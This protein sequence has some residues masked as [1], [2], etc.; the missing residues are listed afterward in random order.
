MKTTRFVILVFLLLAVAGQA[1]AQTT[2][3]RLIGSVVDAGN[4]VLAGVTV[5][6]ASPALI[7]GAQTK[8]TDG[9]GE[10]TFLSIAPGVY[11]LRAELPGFIPQER[12]KVKVPLGGAAAVFIAMPGSA[13]TGEIEVTDLTP[14][15][16]PT[17]VNTG[18]VF[19]QGYMQ[20]S[21]I[22]SGN[23]S[24]T[25]VVNQTA[26]V[27]GGGSWG[28]VAQPRVFG[29]TIGENAYFI[30]GMDSTNPTMATATAVLNF[31]AIDEIQLQTGGFEAE[32]GRATGGIINLVTKSGGNDFSGAFDARY[33]DDSFQESGDHFDAGESSTKHQV[34]SAT[35]GGPILQDRVWFFTSYQWVNDVFTPD[36]SPTTGEEKGQ[37]FLGKLTWQI[38]PGWRLSAKYTSNPTTWDN[39]NASQWVMPEATSHAKDT[40]SILSTELTSVLSDS[41]LWNTTLGTYSYETD[42]YPQSGDLAAIGHYNFD[43][44]LRTVNYGNQQYWETTR[45]D[46]TTDL[47]W[48]VDDLFGS[49]EFKGGIE[50][51]DLNFKDTNCRTGTPNGER[52]VPDGVG[53]FFNDIEY[54][55]S[56]LPYLMTESHTSGPLDYDGTVSTVFVQDAWRPARNVT[57]KLG[58]RYDVV[59]YD[60][61]DGS[62]IADMDKFQPRLGVA[63]DITG[64]A[65]TILRG[66]WGRFLHPNMMTLPRHVR[67]LAEPWY[68]WGSCSV[69]LPT[70]LGITVSSS[71][72]CVAVAEALGFGYR[73]DNAGWD[74]YGWLLMP[75]Q[76]FATEPNRSDPNIRATYADE[77]ILAFERE[78]GDQSSIELTYVD[79]KTRDIV[80]DTCNGNWPTPTADAA[81]DYFFTANIPELKRDYSG[82]TL[83]YET[84]SFEWMTLLASYT[85]SSSKGSID[86]SQG[87]NLEVDH[88]PWHYDNIYGYLSGHRRH[89]IKLNGFFNIK[90]DWTF[91]FDGHWSS[92]F[93]WMPLENQY[94]NP[95]I[96]YGYRALEPRGSREA[97]SNYQ[98]DLQVSKGFALGNLRLEL[99]G[100]VLNA[101]SS[102][103]PTG[104]CWWAS[105]CGDLGMGEASDWQIPRRY[106]VGFRLEF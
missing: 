77:L 15:V 45:K 48:F 70:F 82:I 25:T 80:D 90:G 58:L 74:P 84:R 23:R 28:G 12:S 38:D 99:I 89:R 59:T 20:D 11:S 73:T 98:L 31:D 68:R 32:F 85:Y 75:G 104:I 30:D 56:P 67:T 62:R 106:E 8:V 2:T 39:W 64:D 43:T 57:L 42:V 50:F 24:Y 51:S 81:C 60:T 9:H 96:P 21:A 29:S 72:E 49:H 103:R 33:R 36:G 4:G 92:P 19:D 93:T 34:F 3:G 91:A 105:G 66:S 5:T 52:C 95:E 44:H 6:I 78:V 102:E 27:A 87:G 88:Y 17:Q 63:W 41:L 7:G 100:S 94:D 55:G 69:A 71:E 1:K 79:K 61:N 97:N 22:G 65:K 13:F 101:L 18:Q 53:F 26:G 14:V 35:L 37:N 40:T 76:S 47:S 10:F 83:T 54:G 86:Y 16:D 46:F